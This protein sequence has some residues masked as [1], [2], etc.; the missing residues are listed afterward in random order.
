MQALLASLAIGLS[1]KDSA[2]K[3]GMAAARADAKRTGQDFEREGARMSG[4]IEQSA[5]AINRAFVG[6]AEQAAAMSASVTRSGI[7]LT[8]AVTAPILLAGRS[9]GTTASSFEAAMKRVKSAMLSAT[10]DQIDRLSA[11]AMELGPA[12]GRSAIEAAGAIEMLAKNGMSASGILNGGLASA[13]KLATVGQS[14]LSGAADLTTDVM[15]QFGKTSSELPAIVDQVSGALDVS[16]LGFEDYQLAIAQAGG[17]AGG[18]GFAFEDLN[19]ALAAT[20]S[21]FASGS[22]AGTSF[23]TFLTSLSGNSEEAK[24]TIAALGLQFFDAQGNARGLGEISEEL[25]TK[26]SGLNDQAKQDVLKTIFGT[27]AMR[28]AIGL[29]TQGAAGIDKVRAAIDQVTAED[30]LQVL[31]DGDAAASARLSAES[32]K[33]AVKLGSVLLPVWAG[34]KQALAGVAAS[35]AAM[36]AWFHAS[37][38]VVGLMAASIGPLILAVTALAKV[39]LPLLLLRLGPVAL[40]FAAIINPLGVVIRL[41]GQLAMQAGAA[42]VLGTL[43]ARMVAFAGPIGLA[44]SILAVLAPLMFRTA[45]ASASMAKA[46]ELANERSA[47]AAGLTD[48][49][50]TATG[51]LREELRK[52]AAA[53]ALASLRA[54]EKAKADMLAAKAALARAR[55]E[56]VA[57]GEAARFSGGSAAGPGAGAAMRG[58]GEQG[59]AQ[60]LVELAAANGVLETELQTFG[61]NMKTFREASVGGGAASAQLTPGDGDKKTKSAVDRQRDQDRFDDDMGQLR[62]ARQRAIADLTGSIEEQ[63]RATMLEIDEDRAAFGRQVAADD[64][65][66]AAKRTQLLSAKDAEA[67]ERRGIAERDRFN[68]LEQ[69]SYDLFAARNVAEQE[70]AGASIDMADSMAGRRAGELR[71]LD[72]QKA[73]E[74]AEL[75]LILATKATTS[76]EWQNAKV[77]AD[78]LDSAYA[79][80]ADQVKRDTETPAQRYMRELRRSAQAVGEDI[81]AG[82]VSALDRLNDELAD[83]VMGAGSLSKAFSNMAQSIVR[84]LIR[85]GIQRAIIAPLADSLF[86]RA[87]ESGERPSGG[88]LIGGVASALGGLLGKNG[89]WQGTPGYGGGKAY[90]GRV[91]PGNWYMVGEHGPERFVPETAGSIVPNSGLRASGRSVVELRVLRGELFEPVVEGVSGAVSVRTMREG[92]QRAAMSQR[93]SLG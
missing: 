45:T 72:L 79:A 80:R 32:E 77:R 62:V 61:A 33:L 15:A 37:V 49:L 71:L 13:L 87:G 63:Y 70:M 8:A 82:A 41:L 38:V 26:L 5:R 56:A 93:Q 47:R 24:K 27:D 81:E 52:K 28:T 64:S 44:V 12:M 74:A 19:V 9:M 58:K 18:I 65:L 54:V 39:A 69:E 10:P 29:M 88:G 21:L 36:P 1:V 30:K 83:A 22:D 92:Q 34:L 59:V 35:L 16:K 14:D 7:A 4:A 50:A 48:K 6:I 86:G 23:K 3:A 55:A 57:L 40:G 42:T 17:V 73:R 2:Y 91:G 89:G 90:G 11:A 60:A 20:A 66:T 84:D 75:E 53:D 31:L 67:S 46:Q 51:K 25:R 85:I 43:G 76:A 68:A 78:R